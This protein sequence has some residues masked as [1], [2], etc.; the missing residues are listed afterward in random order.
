MNINYSKLVDKANPNDCY[1]E[2]GI[3]PVD[4]VE[5]IVCLNCGYVREPIYS[6]YEDI[7]D[8]QMQSYLGNTDDPLFSREFNMRTTTTDDNMNKKLLWMYISYSDTVIFNVKK[9][10]EEKAYDLH[11]T[12][13]IV[14]NALHYFKKFIGYKDENGNKSI[15]KG[16][17]KLAII[18]VCVFFSC[19]ETDSINYVQNDIC[20]CFGIEKKMFDEYSKMFHIRVSSKKELETN[21]NDILLNISS[22]MNLDKRHIQVC[23]K[24]GEAIGNFGILTDVSYTNKAIGIVC[25]VLIETYSYD[26]KDIIKKINITM[27]TLNKILKK[28]NENKGII[29]TFIKNK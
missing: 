5:S 27:T 8:D 21:F 20:S 13:C 7:A 6:C 28:L 16:S 9:L 4:T 15:F 2:T 12:K 19:K 3:Y 1:C 11:L 29:Y 23:I 17:N 22:K 14:Q 26:K 10:I 18:A 25:F 24:I